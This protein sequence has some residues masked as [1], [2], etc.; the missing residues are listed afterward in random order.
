MSYPTDRRYT[1]EHEW[2]LPTGRGQVRVGLTDFAQ[3]QL[4]DI[5]SVELPNVGDAYQ[6]GEPF[7][8]VESVKAVSEVYAPVTGEVVAVNGELA[9]SPED[10]N[11]DADATWLIELRATDAGQ[12]D[13]QLDQLL[14]ADQ[15]Q[16]YTA[17]EAA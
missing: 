6:A 9:S 16:A 13:G 3:K 14:D 10:I 1:R 5:V 4:G 8:T 12:L 17:G 11:A 2:A 7:G 15:Y